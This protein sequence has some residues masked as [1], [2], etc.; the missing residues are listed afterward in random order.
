M[1]NKT[2]IRNIATTYL[3][4]LFLCGAAM[5]LPAKA[6]AKTAAAARPAAILKLTSEPTG[7]SVTIDKMPSGATPLA[8]P[9][10][11]GRHLV[12]IRLENHNPAF[13]NVTATADTPAE[14]VK[15]EPVTASVLVQSTPAG[16]TVT[17]DG[18]N[19]GLTPLLMPEL[20]IGS[21]RIEMTLDGYKPQQL[22][23]S[24]TS[25]KPQRINAVL[26]SSS[27]TLEIVSDPA[28]AD[29]AVNGIAR[30]KTPITV[31]KI[32]EGLS[33]VEISNP[34][35]KT[36]QEQVRLVAGEKFTLNAPLDA[37]PAKLSIVTIPEG[38]RIYLD[39]QFKGE[40]PISFEDLPAGEYRIRV[41]KESHETMARTI[42]LA[43]A[44][45]ATEEFRM[46][47]NVGGLI[48]ATSPA[49][50]TVL[51]G[52]RDRGTTVAA[53]NKTDRISEPLEIKDI[54]IGQQ[55]VVFFRKGYAEQKRM[56]DIKRDE[57]VT[58]ETVQLTRQF[59]PDVEV[60][61]QIGVYRGVFVD[62]TD[63]I[64]R[65]ET[66]PGVIRSFM[67]KDIKG[68]RLI[69][70]DTVEKKIPDAPK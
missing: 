24:V 16:A 42:M 53:T 21:Y 67:V 7:A 57:V 5:L 15:L 51:V 61:T 50:V 28:G 14:H 66:D 33:S 10:D 46:T 23:L 35:Y 13:I 52:G 59:I 19:V 1:K 6:S 68:V 39:N 38:A 70:E 64:Y 63:E 56:V 30:G 9:V 55:E 41:E 43:N 22:D 18:A 45:S 4:L 37:I 27:A 25:G 58:L 3:P 60:T 48:L 54:P 69:R 17:R 40:S 62:K 47:A 12:E 11:A 44:Q 34:G 32:P 8:I 36:Y 20:P 29:V 26:A 31:D 2:I 49:G 65:I